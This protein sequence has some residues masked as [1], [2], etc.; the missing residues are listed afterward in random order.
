[1]YSMLGQSIAAFDQY[2]AELKLCDSDHPLTSP[3]HH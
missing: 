2:I 3:G 1:M